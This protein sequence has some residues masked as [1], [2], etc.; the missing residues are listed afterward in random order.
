VIPL[1][2]TA[3]MRECDAREV[4]RRGVDALVEAAGTAVAAQAH[5]ML[6]SLYGRRVGVL[7]GP[8]LNGADGRVAGALLQA[9]GCKVDLISVA[10]Q[11]R[12]LRGYD[13]VIDAAFGLG[14]TRPYEA[15][16]VSAGTK[17]LAVDL[18]SGVDADTG[19]VLGRPLTANVTLALGALKF[20]HVDGDAT[21]VVGQLRF[22]SLGI[23]TPNESALIV[24]AD[25]GG[26]VI[27][28]RDDHKWTHALSVLAGTPPMPGAA[29][30]VCLGALSA[31]ASMVRLESMGKIAKLVSLPP[32]VVR[33]RGPQVDPR[34]KCVVAGPG[35][36]TKSGE[37][38]RERLSDVAMT[39]V[40]DA[41]AL[42]PRM[43]ELAHR[44]PRVLT[45]HAKEFERLGGEV[46]NGRRI[47]SVRRLAAQT[48]CVVLLKGPLTIISTPEGRLRVVNSGTSA[49]ATAGTGDILAGMIG[50]AIARGHDPL[51]AAALSAH[52]HG[53][54]G[55]RLSPYESATSLPSAVTEILATLASAASRIPA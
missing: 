48:G 33:V 30:L 25:L 2:S 3:V 51:D 19:A 42:T 18:P 53:R 10:G 45:P 31:G 34:S 9:R 20:A 15:P 39:I 44:A 27:G 8:G 13:L 41:D 6:G 36:G 35:L 14:C 1:V 37:W 52:L 49:L 7:V 46:V 54:A 16:L 26:Y 21:R 47:A 40:L 4:A 32:E 23:E 50:A 24:D 29:A 17:V 11:P 12:E 22:A 55:S 28:R 43:I 38:L 5:R